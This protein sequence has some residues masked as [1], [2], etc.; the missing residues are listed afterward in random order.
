MNSRRFLY[1]SSPSSCCNSK[2]L[3]ILS[4]DGGMIGRVCLKCRIESDHVRRD[5]LQE[6]QCDFCGE[7][8][9]ISQEVERHRNYYYVCPGCKRKWKLAMLLPRWDE[10]FPYSGLA[11]HQDIVR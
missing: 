8:L 4:R 9:Q 6:L 7:T 5:E 10:L 1:S 11:A 3:L 2:A